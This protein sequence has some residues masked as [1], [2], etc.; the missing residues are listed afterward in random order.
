M[1]SRYKQSEIDLERALR[2]IPLG[3]QTFSKSITQFP[4]G[5]SPFF[6]DKAE[7]CYL[8][9][10]D[11]NQYIDFVSSL[12]AITLGYADPDVNA[13]VSEQ[14][15]KGTLFSLS[16]TLEAE[17]AELIVEMVPCAEMVRFGKNGSDATAGAVRLARAYTGRE[18]VA[19]CGYHGWQDWYVAGTSRSKG[20]PSCLREL[21]HSFQYNNLASLE[22]IF[23]EYPG[24]IAAVIMEPMNIE[25][26]KDNFLEKVKQVTHQHGA[27]LIFDEV[28]TGFRFSKGGAQQLFGVTPDLVALGKGLGNG[29]PLS[30][31]AGPAAIMKLMEEIFYSFTF[32]GELVSLAA[33][34]VVLNKVRRGEVVS[35]IYQ[36]GHYLK[37][38]VQALIDRLSLNSVVSISGHPSWSILSFHDT[39]AVDKW[40]LKT[41]WLQEILKRGILSFGSHNLSCSHTK[42]EVDVL[43]QVYAEV[44]TMLKTRIENNTLEE[45]LHCKVL[46]PL[47]TV[48]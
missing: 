5:V 43:L 7:G 23:H 35:H 36:V 6:A 9:D 41:F 47:F 17:V 20:V 10:V 2:L 48:R 39:N 11:G 42:K 16:S 37:E 13:A 27:L 30:A 22:N 44:F 25:F 14:L 3:A 28:I 40:Q 15:S 34:K 12:L 38:S 33:A 19:T 4:L 46:R 45:A 18:H 8:W 26:P 21:T 1:G 32:G 24:S 29:F 31:I